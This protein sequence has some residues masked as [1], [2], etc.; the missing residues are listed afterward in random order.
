MRASAAIRLEAIAA[1]REGEVVG[2]V[3]IMWGDGDC[4]SGTADSITFAVTRRRALKQAL[5]R[6]ATAAS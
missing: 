6:A 5:T 4:A 3:T 2:G 1:A